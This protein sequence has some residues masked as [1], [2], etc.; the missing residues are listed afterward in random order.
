MESVS[1]IVQ[2]FRDFTIYFK[3]TKLEPVRINKMNMCMSM[4][5]FN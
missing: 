2:D 4:G 1:D 3:G 5:K